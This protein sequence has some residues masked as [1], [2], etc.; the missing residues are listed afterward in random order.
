MG[1]SLGSHI[2]GFAGKTVLSETGYRVGRI[3]GL[4]PAGPCFEDMDTSHRLS[5]NDADYVDVIHTDSG[6][7]GLDEPLGERTFINK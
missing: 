7:F 4:D 2:A 6:M 1:H 5:K 3:S